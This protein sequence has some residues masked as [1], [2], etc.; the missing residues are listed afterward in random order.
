MKELGH[1][2][3]AQHATPLSLTPDTFVRPPLP[4]MSNATAI[5]HAGPAAGAR[6][7]QFTVEFEEGGVLGA[8]AAQRFIYVIE[9]EVRMGGL[10]LGEGGFAYTPQGSRTKVSAKHGTR[11]AVIEKVY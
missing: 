3:S 2:R 6:F 10:S 4:G 7:A 5:V 1:T 9:G 11:A 8:T